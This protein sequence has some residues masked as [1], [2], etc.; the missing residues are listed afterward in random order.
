MIFLLADSTPLFIA[1]S[2]FRTRLKQVCGPQKRLAYLG[3]S[4]IELCL[5]MLAQGQTKINLIIV[6]E[7]SKM[8]ML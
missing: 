7:H 3:A 6:D 2:N 1:N 8:S 4:N 5:A